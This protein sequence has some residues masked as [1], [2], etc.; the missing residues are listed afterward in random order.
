L[1]RRIQVVQLDKN[2]FTSYNNLQGFKF[3]IWNM[4]HV[5]GKKFT[6]SF[7]ISLTPRVNE[8]FW[9]NAQGMR[10]PVDI[11]EV[12]DHLDCIVDGAVIKALCAQFF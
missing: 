4:E 10:N 7:K 11:V 12:G 9:F 8:I 2:R 3:T 6:D 1:E 5:N